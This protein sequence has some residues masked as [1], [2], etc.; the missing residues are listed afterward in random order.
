MKVTPPPVS[1]E[2]D[3]FALR[4]GVAFLC[5]LEGEGLLFSPS[6]SKAAPTSRIFNKLGLMCGAIGGREP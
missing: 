2:K 6:S 3:G 1:A 5:S 4:V